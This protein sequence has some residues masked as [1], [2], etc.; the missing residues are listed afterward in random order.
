VA[1]RARER[2]GHELISV[3]VMLIE[4]APF[5]EDGN[6]Q[7]I[8]ESPR[9]STLKLKYDAKNSVF[10]V[11]RALP[12]GLAYPFDW[13]FIPGTRAGDG[14]PVDALVVHDSPTYPGVLLPC[15]IL[16]MVALSQ[17]QGGKREENNRIIALP[18]WSNSVGEIKATTDLP[19]PLR[20]QLEQFFVDNTF[21]TGKRIR[22]EGWHGPRAA[23]RMIHSRLRR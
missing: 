19:K 7:V 22:L 1:A 11:G 14:D 12:A 5:D 4:I 20:V 21:F 10:T 8:V 9:G 3:P 23:V 6:L 2:P 18:A 13:G 16:G 17:V 15:R